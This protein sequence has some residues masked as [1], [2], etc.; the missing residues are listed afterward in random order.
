MLD[1][2]T[3]AK[4]DTIS[5][6]KNNE[7]IKYKD[8]L[9]NKLSFNKIDNN[10]KYIVVNEYYVARPDLISLAVYGT[11]KYADVI[12]KINGISNPFELNEDMVLFLPSILSIPGFFKVTNAGSDV[13]EK[14]LSKNYKLENNN[15]KKILNRVTKE[16]ETISKNK[17]GLQKLKNE[18]R[19]PSEQTINDKNYYIDRSL[20]LVIY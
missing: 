4:K 17:V 14:Y 6:I 2:T 3:L 20:G 5:V 10:G 19:S 7:S 12:C 8:L 9:S 13:L 11:D 1:Y 16:T 18:R 15:Y